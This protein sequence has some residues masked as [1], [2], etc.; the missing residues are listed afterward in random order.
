MSAQLER[1][2]QDR[3]VYEGFGFPVVLAH[4]PMVRVRGAWTPDVDLNELSK[5]LLAALP[6]KP[7]RLTG[8]EVRFIRHSLSMTLEDFAHRFD[9]THP[10]VIKWERCSNQ[11]TSMAWA[12]EK[13]IRLEVAKRTSPGKPSKF[14]ETYQEL[15]KIPAR[16]A[17]RVRIDLLQ[18]A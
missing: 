5:S 13:D 10:A 15:A 14:L 12:L 1:K 6:E 3:F 16:K 11:P 17:E 8:S 9:V 4:V 18:P 7:T 2:T